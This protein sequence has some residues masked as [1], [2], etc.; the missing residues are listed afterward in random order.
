[1]CELGCVNHA[2][3]HARVTQPSPRIFLHVCTV[4][5]LTELTSTFWIVTQPHSRAELSYLR[6]ESGL[7]HEPNCLNMF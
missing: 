7:S 2:Q 6:G 1:M 4:I 5:L 3:T